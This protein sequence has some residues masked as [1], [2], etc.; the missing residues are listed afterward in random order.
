[1]NVRYFEDLG[2]W[3]VWIADHYA[4][5]LQPD[6]LVLEAWTTLAA[7]AAS[8]ARIRLGTL[9][10]NVAT[11]HPALLAKQAATVDCVDLASPNLLQVR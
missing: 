9:V 7:L 5:P 11:R 2:I 1:M 4:S 10:T 3:T 8:T 6:R